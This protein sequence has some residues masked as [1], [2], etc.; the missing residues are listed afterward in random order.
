[1]TGAHPFIRARMLT[2]LTTEEIIARLRRYELDAGLIHPFIENSDDIALTPLY[3]EPMVVAGPSA[4]LPSDRPDLT[5]RELAAL[6]HCLLEPHMRARQLLD[7]AFEGEGLT[8]A[9]RI[10]TDS[11]EALLALARTG[12]W[13]VV[14][15][16]SAVAPGSPREDIRIVGLVEPVV[17]L[18]I[19]LAQLAGEPSPPVAVAIDLAAAQFRAGA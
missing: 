8:L 7:A 13:V 14:V 19:A 2:G 5:G 12:R 6:P 16:R 4:L 10:E 9:P 18:P 17:T 15:P 1:L 11:I 3:D